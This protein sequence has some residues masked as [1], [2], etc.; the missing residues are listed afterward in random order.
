M[1]PEGAIEALSQLRD[2]HSI[3]LVQTPL[4]DE[5]FPGLLKSW[6]RT[7]DHDDSTQRTLYLDL[8]QITD[9]SIEVMLASDRLDFEDAFVVLPEGVS[10]A[11]A[12]KLKTA[13]PGWRIIRYD[14]HRQA[15]VLGRDR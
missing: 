5:L 1:I 15:T 11:A 8:T 2:V 4:D 12:E 7:S 13:Y 10:L 14:K 3:S 6:E 9:R